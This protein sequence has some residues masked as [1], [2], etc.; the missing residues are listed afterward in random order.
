MFGNE[1]AETS[2]AGWNLDDLIV[3]RVR[4]AAGPGVAVRRITYPKGTFADYLKPASL[5][6][7]PAIK[8]GDLVRQVAGSANCERYVVVTRTSNSFGSSNQTVEGI[9]IVGTPGTI[10]I[11]ASAIL[12]AL[13]NIQIFDGR[14]FSVTKH[15]VASTSDQPAML[16]GLTDRVVGPH[17]DFEETAFPRSPS[18]VVSN[19]VLRDGVR[20]LLTASLDRT[21]PG[22]LG[23]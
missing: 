23:R 4:A 6:S 17:R 13:T 9:G 19:A 15:D 11:K 21:L 14:D 7:S 10:I 20:A 2:V 5:F 12:F 22:L 8:F 18:D 16:R 1:H 3:A